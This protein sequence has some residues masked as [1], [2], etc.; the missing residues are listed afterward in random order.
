MKRKFYITDIEIILPKLQK[1][2]KVEKL[3]IIFKDKMSTSEFDETL[4]QLL[5]NDRPKYPPN[6]EQDNDH[7]TY[8]SN[9]DSDNDSIYSEDSTIKENLN[10]DTE[11]MSPIIEPIIDVVSLP[12]IGTT[13]TDTK[14][15]QRSYAVLRGPVSA[16]PVFVGPDRG[17]W[18]SRTELRTAGPTFRSLL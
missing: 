10:I 14:D 18:R 13:E 3:S 6:Q 5:Q 4:E 11:I 17:P 16:G 7:L 1:R 8:D 9:K 15:G 2:I 12:D